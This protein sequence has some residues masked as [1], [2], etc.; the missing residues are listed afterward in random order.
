M[1][2]RV[3]IAGKIEGNPDYVRQFTEA[4]EAIRKS[5]RRPINPVAFVNFH[6]RIREQECQPE[7]ERHEIMKLCIE[8]LCTC[9]EIVLLR[10]WR[11]SPGALLEAAVAYNLNLKFYH[12]SEELENAEA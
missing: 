10:N 1:I 2:K 8:K 5:G 11:E 9:H 6:N 12:L 3:Y 7:M 4:A